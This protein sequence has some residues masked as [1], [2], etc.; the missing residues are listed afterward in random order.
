MGILLKEAEKIAVNQN[1]SEPRDV[2]SKLSHHFLWS[3]EMA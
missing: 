1:L 2:L 3:K